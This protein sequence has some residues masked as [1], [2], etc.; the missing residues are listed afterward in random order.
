MWAGRVE[1]P[2]STKNRVAVASAL[3]KGRGA[4]QRPWRTDTGKL[5]HCF[6]TR[7]AP[8]GNARFLEK[9]L[10]SAR[11][12]HLEAARQQR[13]EGAMALPLLR[14]KAEAGSV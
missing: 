2:L 5:A 8:E 7:L 9:R 3:W 12:L 10:G 4:A 11:G 14:Y 13:C 1:R 6:A